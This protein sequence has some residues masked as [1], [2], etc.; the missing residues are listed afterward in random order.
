MY[1]CVKSDL[2]SIHSVVDRSDEVKRD[3][4]EKKK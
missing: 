2:L 4:D 1:V 3:V